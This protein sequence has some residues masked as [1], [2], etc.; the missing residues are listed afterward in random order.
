MAWVGRADAVA[1]TTS[2]FLLVLALLAAPLAAGAFDA[3]S[4][5][6]GL[7]EGAEGAGGAGCKPGD[8]FENGEVR[9]WFHGKKGFVKVFDANAS[10]QGEE[11]GSG[12]HYAYTTGEVAELDGSGRRVAWMGLEHAYPKTGACQVE[13][14]E[15]AV[16]MT[17]SVTDD[18]RASAGGGGVVGQATVVFAY[19]FNKSSQGAKFDL[20]VVD[21]P[22]RSD[23]G[24]LAYSFDVHAGGGA[25]MDPAENGVGIR[26]DDGAP[27]GYVEWAPNATATY[28]DGHQETAVVDADTRVD[29]GTARVTL[30]FTNAT[31]G[32]TR[33]DYDPWAGVGPYLV[34]GGRLVG[35]APAEATVAAVVAALVRATKPLG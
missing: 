35:L 31:A 15:D 20:R 29:G 4:H 7:P 17:L 13:E 26:G 6:T 8:V 24:L 14:T 32:H 23:D 27:R 3:A 19:H 33:L 18:V 30:A 5:A 12:A 11:G 1:R 25:T 9:L 34:V 16:R 22:W 21:W 10:R 28:A 2:T